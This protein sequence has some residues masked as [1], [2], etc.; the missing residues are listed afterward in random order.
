MSTKNPS[1]PKKLIF[2]DY[3]L[4]IVVAIAVIVAFQGSPPLPVDT[5]SLRLLVRIDSLSTADNNSA[6]HNAQLLSVLQ[7][8]SS[9]AA[10]ARTASEG[11][12]MQARIIFIS[13]LAALVTL[14]SKVE[15][16]QLTRIVYLSLLFLMASMFFLDVQNEDS[17]N[18]Q[19][20]HDSVTGAEI[21]RLAN[22][23]PADLSWYQLSYKE[24]SA[25]FHAVY[26]IPG[27]WMRKAQVACQPNSGRIVFFVLPW[28]LV[29]WF[30]RPTFRRK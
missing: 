17:R 2:W 15:T 30:A 5:S 10:I 8:E 3:F 23:N 22:I 1:R 16:M 28:F 12:A 13:F 29:Y 6:Q 18:I 9:S 11:G 21:H 4:L 19:Y 25:R 20:V 27:R 7:Q 24:D 14:V 26:T